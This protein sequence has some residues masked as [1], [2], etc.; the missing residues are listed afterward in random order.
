[1]WVR[2]GRDALERPRTPREAD[3]PREAENSLATDRQLSSAAEL[4]VDVG[5]HRLKLAAEG[6]YHL[7]VPLPQ[8]VDEARARCRFDKKKRTLTVTMPLLAAGG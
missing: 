1:M 6:V 8:A 7:D 3:T 2:C 4:E 5:T